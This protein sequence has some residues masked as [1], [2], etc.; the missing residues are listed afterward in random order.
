MP[1]DSRV[2]IH[3]CPLGVITYSVK[4]SSMPNLGQNLFSQQERRVRDESSFTRQ[5]NF[6]VHRCR[7]IV[8]QYPITPT[9]FRHDQFSGR[10]FNIEIFFGVDDV[11]NEDDRATRFDDLEQRASAFASV[12]IW[13]LGSTWFGKQKWLQLMSL[14]AAGH[15][16]PDYEKCLLSKHSKDGISFR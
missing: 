8:V 3:E 10:I 4:F 15:A 9:P 11:W 13:F 16:I 7:M 6:D 2:S 14:A 12:L 5:I 1:Q